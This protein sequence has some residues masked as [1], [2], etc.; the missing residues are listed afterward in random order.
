[1]QQAEHWD[2]SGTPYGL[3]GVQIHPAARVLAVAVAVVTVCSA[4]AEGGR[5]AYATALDD[6]ATGAGRQFDPALVRLVTTLW[7]A[8]HPP[9]PLLSGV[10]LGQGAA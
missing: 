5:P 9:A 2:G 7:P 1:A 8:G 3:R 10:A 4:P 6:L